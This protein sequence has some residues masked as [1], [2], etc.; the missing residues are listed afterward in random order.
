MGCSSRAHQ[1]TVTGSCAGLPAWVCLSAFGV[2]ISAT[3]PYIQAALTHQFTY[4]QVMGTY[5]VIMMVITAFVVRFGPEAHRVT[6][7]QD[8]GS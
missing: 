7:G 1:R 5:A 4:A 6:F 3:A 8:G 2:L